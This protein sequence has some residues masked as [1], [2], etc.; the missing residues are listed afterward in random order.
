M[1]TETQKALCDD[2]NCDVC[3]NRS[4]ASNS[5]KCDRFEELNGINPRYIFKCSHKIY[6]F[7]C[8]KCCHIFDMR[9]KDYTYHDCPFCSKYRL[10]GKLDCEHCYK[11]SFASHPKSNFF[12]KKNGVSPINI[13][14]NSHTKYIFDCPEC[15]HE[16]IMSL[17]NVNDGSWCSFCANNQLCGKCSI[18][19]EKSF[20]SHLRSKNFSQKNG[21]SPI[22]IFKN[23]NKKYIFDCQECAHEFIISAASVNNGQ[24]CSFCANKQLCGECTI[25]LEKSFASHS[26]SIYFSSKNN[27]SPKYIF[28]KSKKKYLFECHDCNHNFITYPESINKGHWC[29]YC[30]GYNLCGSKDC[31]F[32]YKKSLASF[33]Y[34]KNISFSKDNNVSEYQVHK[35]SHKKYLFDCNFCKHTFETRV[36]DLISQNNGCPYCTS[37]ILCECTNCI[38]CYEK[39]FASVYQSKFWSSKNKIKPRF[40]FK[41]SNKKFIFNCNFCEKD[42]EICLNNITQQNNWCTCTFNKTETKLYEWLCDKY[43]NYTVT[44]QSKFN[45]CVY[46]ETRKYAKYDFVINELKIIIEL[47]GIQHFKEMKHWYSNPDENQK[48]DVFK[49]KRA[50]KNGYTIIHLLQDDVWRNKQYKKSI[51]ID[52]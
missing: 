23:T 36:A 32:C 47:D 51:F 25:C 27:I 45:W 15:C 17:L 26:K 42:F 19:F 2:L 28:K 1:C 30:N 40:V 33:K 48:K 41:N 50:I 39:S 11:S 20:A 3:F 24:W 9:L 7:Y 44:K 5:K 10:C 35:F 12:S 8:N 6:T 34:Q 22:N 16:F 29:G 21:V 49:I 46:P 37:T 43:E 38:L 18:C 31:Q 52:N 14:K 13:F 4:L